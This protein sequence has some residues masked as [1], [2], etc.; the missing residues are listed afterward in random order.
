MQHLKS[1]TVEVLPEL[2]KMGLPLDELKSLV[3]DIAGARADTTKNDPNTAAGYEAWRWGTR[4]ARENQVFKDNGYIKCEHDQIDGIRN[5]EKRIK[6]VVCN[7]DSRTCDEKKQPRNL[8]PKKTNSC[9]LIANNKQMDCLFTESEM[10]PPKASSV[11]DYDFYYL[12]VHV[13]DE[14]VLAELSR[15]DEEVGGIVKSFS[16]RLAIIKHGEMKSPKRIKLDDI[17][18]DF[19]DVKRPQPKRKT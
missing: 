6:I 8:S 12:C 13:G 7:T 14:F 15:P 3:A 11:S 2:I 9:K 5:D 4:K 18:Q 19:A 17:E 16:N 1:T 10:G